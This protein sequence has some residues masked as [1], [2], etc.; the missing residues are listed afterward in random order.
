M[1]ILNFIC[2]L[3]TNIYIYDV[4]LCEK[5]PQKNLNYIHDFFFF[6]L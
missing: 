1:F 4:S 6:Q 3:H 5:S 2:I